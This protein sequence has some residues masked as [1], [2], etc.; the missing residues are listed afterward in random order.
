MREL[1]ALR[2]D[3]PRASAPRSPA[4]GKAI[5]VAATLS[6]LVALAGSLGWTYHRRQVD[7]QVY[8]MGARHLRSAQLY[9]LYLP[10]V[11]L[12]FTYPPFS[13]V[14]FWPL[15][16]FPQ[17][18]AEVLWA[19]INLVAVLAILAVSLR[20]V[21]PL[22]REGPAVPW[23]LVWL[24]AGPAV[25]LEPFMLDLSF[26]QVNAVLVALVLTDLTTRV[27]VGGREVPRG[28]GVALAAAIKLVPLIFIAY[29]AVTRQLRAAATA[30]V[31]FAVLT[32][33]AAAVNPSASWAYWTRYVNDQ[34]RIGTVTYISNQSLEGALDRWAHHALSAHVVDLVALVAVVGGL[35][36]GRWAWRR[37]SSVLAVLVVA[38]TGLLASPITWCHH[39]VWIAPVLVWLC[40]GADR[41]AGGRWWAL[42][43]ATLFY[44]APMW[45]IAHGPRFDIAESRWAWVAGSSFTLAGAA[46]L[47][48]VAAMLWRRSKLARVAS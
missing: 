29:L 6:L 43:T 38:D 33:G 36:L 30:A 23:T 40:W 16:A 2:C 20:A 10:G 14:F 22:E 26:G 45:R 21:A 17:G 44:V 12:P 19:L 32:L 4:R 25:L 9:S 5:T 31:G 47:V 42:A 3:D 8:L 37:S 15:T 13:T 34:S 46:F 11:H 28:L 35:A 24:L 7:I 41:P 18:T 1:V 48:A 27:R 39:M